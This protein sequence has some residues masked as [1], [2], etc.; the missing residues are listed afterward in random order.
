MLVNSESMVSMREA[1]QNF[2]KVARQ[3]ESSGPVVI[4]KNNRPQYIVMR[5]DD[6]ENAVSIDNQEETVA[7]DVIAQL[8]HQFAD[9][10]EQALR[11]LAK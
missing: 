2:S 5:F 1:N 4:M 9:N 11:E 10:Y 6:V 7:D 8:T 3:V